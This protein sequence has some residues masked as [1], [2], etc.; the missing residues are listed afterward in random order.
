MDTITD[1]INTAVL[2]LVSFAKL[3]ADKAMNVR[4]VDNYNARALVPGITA[5]GVT[6]PLLVSLRN[7]KYRVLWGFRRYDAIEIVKAESPEDFQ[8]H[9]D[10]GVKCLVVEG[11]TEAEELV[12]VVDHGDIKT[13]KNPYEVYLAASRF[14]DAGYAEKDVVIRLATLIDEIAPMNAESRSKMDKAEA[15][16]EKDD[17]LFKNRRGFIQNLHRIW[18]LPKQVHDNFKDLKVRGE[19]EIKLT[20]TNI[21]A[22]AKAFT[23]DIKNA[24]EEGQKPGTYTKHN[25][26]PEYNKKW[27]EVVTDAKKKAKAPKKPRAW[28]TKRIEEYLPNVISDVLSAG[29]KMAAG[30]E[31]AGFG[32][33]AKDEQAYYIERG[34]E[35]CPDEY[36]GFIEAVKA[37]I[38]EN[39]AGREEQ[40]KSA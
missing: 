29:L 23:A 24:S 16:S 7:G 34:K 3:L 22:L 31:S 25:P 1:K 36:E 5:L 12:A 32:I 33:K 15:Q 38:E 27:A 2:T 35:L 30:D 37:A 28:G 26:G 13:L 11:L 19:A 39:N 9:F 10:S 40:V 4:L 21:T 17:I 8:K 6:T 18:R 20:T 14:F